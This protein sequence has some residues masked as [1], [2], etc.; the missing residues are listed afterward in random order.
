[1]D[2]RGILYAI[3]SAGLFGAGTPLAKIL[4]GEI[5]PWLLAGIL[6]GG[7]G[8][9]LWAIQA[10]RRLVRGDPI[11]PIPRRDIPVLSCAIFFGG[12]AGPVLLMYG[13]S[14]TTAAAASLLLNLEGLATMA[15]AWMVF[16]ENL[17]R[18]LLLG[19]GLILAGA[20]VVSWTPD[21]GPGADASSAGSIWIAAA[22]LAWGIDNNLTRHVS[23]T[24]AVRIAAWKG[25]VAG[26][27][28]LAIALAAG[29]Q[30]PSSAWLGAAG[31]LGF[32]SYGVSLSLFVLALRHLGAA[33][34][35]AY[36][37]TAPFVGAVLSVL[38]LS[39]AVSPSLG[40]AGILM[41]AGV[42]LHVSERHDHEHTH[43]EMEHTHRHEHDE[44]H[45]HA[46]RAGDPPGEPHSHAHR[47]D[48][49]R[50][51]HPHYPDI[52]HRHEHD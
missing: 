34:T 25:S 35:G 49:L 24:D 11:A 33:R 20:A 16:R 46:H 23:S 22:C 2:R 12:V 30:L 15:I 1:M 5:D 42:W 18:R 51:R 6:Y 10:G 7:S 48:P 8:I 32:A 52:H 14:Q 41:L 44:H 37:S 50:H 13:L 36:F 27:I 28:N 3:L 43:E 45:R 38:L 31:L 29:V 17:D 4:L 47:H 39:E 21:A 26:L 19:A 40:L 9:G